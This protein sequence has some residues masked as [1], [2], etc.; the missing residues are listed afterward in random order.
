[1]TRSLVF[2]R[3]DQKPG[4]PGRGPLGAFAPVP[5]ARAAELAS[6]RQSSPPSRIRDQ[7]TAAPAGDLDL[8]PFDGALLLLETKTTTLDP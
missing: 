8:A 2:R 4:V 5:F 3:K 6:L 1:M 7:S